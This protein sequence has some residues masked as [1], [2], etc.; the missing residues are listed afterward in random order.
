MQNTLPPRIGDLV[1][2]GKD[3]LERYGDEDA[4]SWGAVVAVEQFTVGVKWQN[5]Q[6][7]KRYRYGFNGFY[8]VEIVGRRGPCGGDL[9]IG[10]AVYLNSNRIAIIRYIGITH[11]CI[12]EDLYGVEVKIAEEGEPKG[13]HSG[14]LEG[15][16][17]FQAAPNTGIFISRTDIKCKL[18]PEQLVLLSLR[19]DKE[20][21]PQAFL[22]QG[23]VKGSR[24]AP[25]PPR[26]AAVSMSFSGDMPPPP[27]RA[28][29]PVRLKSK[30]APL[31]SFN[32]EPIV[33]EPSDDNILPKLPQMTTIQS[34]P[35]VGSKSRSAPTTPVSN[36]DNAQDKLILVNDFRLKSNSMQD[37]SREEE[38]AG[39]VFPNKINFPKS[40]SSY[41]QGH[42]KTLTSRQADIIT[43]TPDVIDVGNARRGTMGVRFSVD[44]NAPKA[45]RKLR[46]K[47]TLEKTTSEWKVKW[48]G[49]REVWEN[50]ETG[51][52]DYI[53]Q[54]LFMSSA[55]VASLAQGSEDQLLEDLAE[56]W[57]CEHCQHKNSI[58]IPLCEMCNNLPPMGKTPQ[59]SQTWS[60]PRCEWENSM[61]TPVCLKCRSLPP[62]DDNTS[63]K[64]RNDI[65]ERLGSG[66]MKRQT[67]VIFSPN[68][69]AGL[70]NS[71]SAQ[72]DSFVLDDQPPAKPKK[73]LRRTKTFKLG[74]NKADPRD[75]GGD[76]L[77]FEKI[78]STSLESKV[79]TRLNFR[80]ESVSKSGTNEPISLSSLPSMRS[81]PHLTI[82]SAHVESPRPIPEHVQGKV[83][84]PVELKFAGGWRNGIITKVGDPFLIVEYVYNNETQEKKFALKQ[85]GTDALKKKLRPCQMTFEVRPSAMKDMTEKEQIQEKLNKIL[86]TNKVCAD[87]TSEK[88]NWASLNL[89]VVICSN[90]A[91]VH[92]NMGVH[93]SQVRSLTLD[94]WTMEMVDGIKVNTKVNSIL[95]FNVPPE[96]VKP[97]AT[98]KREVFEK[99]INAK[100]VDKKF[101]KRADIG[102]NPPKYDHGNRR[103]ESNMSQNVGMIEYNGVCL[104]HIRNC[105]FLPNADFFSESDPYIIVT[106]GEFQK[107]RTKHVQ[108]DNNPTFNELVNL[109]VQERKPIKV[110][111]FHKKRFLQDVVLAEG[112]FM[113]D[114]SETESYDIELSLRPGPQFQKHGK[115]IKIFLSVT[116]TKL[117]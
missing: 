17:Y 22:P 110:F 60:C 13:E 62:L 72:R 93:I 80:A 63:Q 5:N 28:P 117:S 53:P 102:A 49:G 99:Y 48:I 29:P 50:K 35:I 79:S 65:R 47:R 41:Q 27:D 59:P 66:E 90:C 37:L 101:E 82:D 71:P 14:S 15:V 7:S 84:E 11:F 10:D 45:N 6:L 67:S 69:F 92:R 109:T 70:A 114:P 57:T 24:P 96:Y 34:A 4:S 91:G 56:T 23:R 21:S 76:E 88:P 51:E 113:L 108:N 9:D 40:S 19:N 33:G 44:V 58:Q 39:I 94:E 83:G 107:A 105:Q 103:M 38:V 106:N 73:R 78:E 32:T 95:E 8:D 74:M 115:D 97:H 81:L 12:D 3:W 2:R 18:H 55:A 16:E 61:E 31:S 68:D 46:R 87:C 100:Y 64:M 77:P 85:L 98:S 54:G 1:R 26:S 30:K 104:I 89:G 42:D 116:Y 20:I 86:D 25:P 36:L 75:R 43:I 112:Q 52:I 111:V